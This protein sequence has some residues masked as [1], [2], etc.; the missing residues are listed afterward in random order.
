M[1]QVMIERRGEYPPNYPAIRDAFPAIARFKV[2]FAYGNVIY[3]PDM[4]DIPPHVWAHEEVHSARQGRDP[5][6]WWI[7]YIDDPAFRLEEELLAHAMELQV[8]TA[9]A[10]RQIRRSSVKLLARKISAPIYGP[11]ITSKAAR[12]EIL[13][14]MDRI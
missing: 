7:R 8:L 12:T 3:N 1:V 11:M 4:M 6:G 10:S 9:G 14:A 2:I 5:V 13:E